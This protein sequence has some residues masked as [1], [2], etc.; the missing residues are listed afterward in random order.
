MDDLIR[1]NLLQDMGFSQ[2]EALVYH[3]L[4]KESPLSGYRIAEITD[5]SRSNTYQA[6]KTLS[7]K[8]Y[9][10]LTEGNEV[11]LYIPVPLESLLEQKDLEFQKR[12]LNVREAFKNL[13]TEKT[14]N[15]IINLK[16]TEQFITKIREMIS[17]AE[18]I[19]IID[20]VDN[21]LRIVKSELAE[22]AKRGVIVMIESMSNEQIDGCIMVSN[23]RFNNRDNPWN[24]D[25][26]VLSV[27]A[28]EFLV[29][30]VTKEGNLINAV[31][32]N[33]IFVSSWFANGMRLDL[34]IHHIIKLFQTEKSKDEI[35][36][37]IESFI[38]LYLIETKGYL[39]ILNYMKNLQP[40]E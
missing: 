20:T 33:N 11:S 8:G 38:Q 15:V 26:F 5:K 12:K 22:A 40:K 1:L 37:D 14:T 16:T 7:Q 24:V 35:R 19:I 32:V 6:L 28:R 23:Q 13:R 25:W 3:T 36:Q 4:L 31:W 9:V 27:D 10:N 18:Q 39:D 21:P 29:A 30:F 17:R 34:L 2:A